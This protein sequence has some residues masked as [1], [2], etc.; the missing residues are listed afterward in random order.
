MA[1]FLGYVVAMNLVGYYGRYISMKGI[2]LIAPWAHGYPWSYL[3]R[4]YISISPSSRFPFD[5]SPIIEFRPVYLVADVVL[6]MVIIV[7]TAIVTERQLRQPRP[8]QFRVKGL[9]IVT[10]LVAVVLASHRYW[11]PDWNVW[12]S[13]HLAVWLSVP[14]Y[15]GIACVLYVVGL[16]FVPHFKKCRVKSALSSQ[17]LAA[18]IERAG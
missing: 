1:L 14:F 13:V 5:D 6:A 10:A 8:F 9:L 15:V 16:E 7:C 12:L 2:E 11:H 18:H 3:E 4:E 17:K